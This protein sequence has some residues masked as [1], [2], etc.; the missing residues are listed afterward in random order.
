MAQTSHSARR[1]D[2]I[3]GNMVVLQE[4]FNFHE[5]HDHRLKCQKKTRA[6][7]AILFLY[8]LGEH[9]AFFVP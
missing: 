6:Q 9:L 1:T 7:W 8:S 3:P 5:F 4:L 2:T